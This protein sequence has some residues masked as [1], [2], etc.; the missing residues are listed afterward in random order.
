MKAWEFDKAG[1]FEE[2]QISEVRYSE[3]REDQC[4]PALEDTGADQPKTC[5]FFLM[6]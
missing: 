3:K 1:R 2:M 6:V 4:M 5:C